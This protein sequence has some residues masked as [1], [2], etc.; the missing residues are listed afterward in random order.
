MPC[1]RPRC[2]AACSA[3]YGGRA[4]TPNTS[5][6][7][8]RHRHPASAVLPQ[9]PTRP[10]VLV[11]PPP[12][13]VSTRHSPAP[14]PLPR[15]CPRGVLSS[16]SNCCN[17][18]ASAFKP[19]EARDILHLVNVV[20]ATVKGRCQH[21]CPARWQLPQAQR[22]AAAS[23]RL[24]LGDAARRGPHTLP[25]GLQ[26]AARRRRSRPPLASTIGRWLHHRR[27]PLH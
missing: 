20:A 12:I 17:S 6:Q 5:R 10:S 7:W 19:V 26:E 11:A 25:H 8:C 3:G 13:P 18:A 2:S 23:D 16:R 4:R 22:A 24:E 27:W 9:P 14:L 21:D 1:G 15:H